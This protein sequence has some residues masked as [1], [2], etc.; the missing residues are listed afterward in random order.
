VRARASA[1]G[2]WLRPDRSSEALPRAFLRTGTRWP[3]ADRTSGNGALPSTLPHRYVALQATPRSRC[4]PRSVCARPQAC[5]ATWKS[6]YIGMAALEDPNNVPRM[7]RACG[8]CVAPSRRQPPKPLPIREEPHNGVPTRSDEGRR[9]RDHEWSRGLSMYGAIKAR[10]RSGFSL[11]QQCPLLLCVS[12]ID[13]HF[14]SS[15]LV[16]DSG[17]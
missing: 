10:I 6:D 8:D 4:L 14:S 17:W 11:R 15:C 3:K 1:A 9:P 7:K 12:S 2:R 5:G 13:Y 16:L